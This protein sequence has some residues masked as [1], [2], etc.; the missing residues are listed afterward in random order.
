MQL[1][2]LYT[3]VT[4]L[5]GSLKLGQ[6]QLMQPVSDTTEKR[7]LPL[8]PAVIEVEVNCLMTVRDLHAVHDM[9]DQL[10]LDWFV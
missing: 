5:E 6:T 10:Q 7:S 3:P 4:D 8:R 1:F 2:H 9:N